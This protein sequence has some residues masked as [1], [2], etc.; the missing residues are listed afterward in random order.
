MRPLACLGLGSILLLAGP[1]AAVPVAVGIGSFSGSAT[2]VDFNGLANKTVIANQYSGL[3]ITFGATPLYANSDPLTAA[4]IGGSGGFVATN[5]VT[6]LGPP[7]PAGCY[8]PITIDLTDPALRI[9]FQVYNLDAELT[10]TTFAGDPLVSTG[11]LV[12]TTGQ[13]DTFV[14]VE[15]LSGIDRIVLTSKG[16]LLDAVVIDNVRFDPVPEPSTGLLLAA[17]LAVLTAARRRH[18]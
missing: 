14:G 18:D 11:S 5:F 7:C 16:N 13:K 17:G 10:V 8:G 2:L 4:V 9:G 1:A 6:P 15:D 12:F 3:G